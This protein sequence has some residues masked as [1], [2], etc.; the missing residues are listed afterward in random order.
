MLG[1]KM[2]S[3]FIAELPQLTKKPELIVMLNGVKSSGYDPTV[4]NALRGDPDF[5]PVTLANSLHLSKVLEANVGYTGF[6]TDKHGQSWRVTPRITLIVNELATS[7][8]LK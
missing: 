1:L 2:L 5:G 8:G 7:L 4:E 6:A 3:R